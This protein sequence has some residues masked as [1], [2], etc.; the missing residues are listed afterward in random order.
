MTVLVRKGQLPHVEWIDLKNNRVLV[1]CAVMKRDDFG[2]IYYIELPSLDRIDKSRMAKILMNRHAPNFPLW[3]LMA[4]VTLNN[5][6][7]SLEYFHQLV[8]IITPDG[9]VM[10]PRAGTVGAGRIDLNNEAQ[11][12][13]ANMGLSG[14][15]ESVQSKSKKIKDTE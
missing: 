13:A 8:K 1:E 6:M 7:N 4:Q 2:N 9:V 5:G 15:V 10:A 14:Q 3:D 11:V 12:T